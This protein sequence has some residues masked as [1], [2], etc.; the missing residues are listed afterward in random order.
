[1]RSVIPLAAVLMLGVLHAEA[2]S[3]ASQILQQ[4]PTNPSSTSIIVSPSAAAQAST[5]EI[6]FPFNSIVA[7]ADK[8]KNTGKVSGI[9]LLSLK[10]VL[11][12]GHTGARNIVVSE[13]DLNGPSR[14]NSTNRDYVGLY[15]RGIANSGDGGTATKFLGAVF[16]I[17]PVA[18]CNAGA[19]FL[20]DCTAGE[21]DVGMYAGASSAYRVGQRIMSFGTSKGLVLDS[22]IQF[23]VLDHA[24]TGFN[25][26]ISF[27]SFGSTP[28]PVTGTLIAGV[29]DGKVPLTAANGIDLSAY[30]FSAASLALPHGVSV[31]GATGKTLAP[32]LEA[33]QSL[34]PKFILNATGNAADGKKWQWFVDGRGNL[35]LTSI[36]DAESA[37]APAIIV[38]RGSGYGITNVVVTPAFVA[39]GG[40]IVMG[41]MTADVYKSA[42]AT[43]VSC[44]VGTVNLSTL[45]IT[46]GIV[47][48]C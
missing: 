13:V 38:N 24:S 16:G 15:A 35:V 25:Y 18:A 9:S 22:G 36:N 30:T 23:G 45:A 12:G 20:L 5:S 17:N 47:T 10:D 37:S 19:L 40:A 6:D 7:L 27:G 39:N 29:G 42:G 31:D 48:H 8:A 21:S 11:P 4:Q 32:V 43:G 41:G 28:N 34:L 44:P 3:P 2:Q 1:M 14:S 33:Q 46:N 26:G